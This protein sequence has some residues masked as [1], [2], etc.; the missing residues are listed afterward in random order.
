MSVQC[1]YIPESNNMSGKRSSGRV[2]GLIPF[3]AAAIAL[4]SARCIVYKFSLC[5][6]ICIHTTG[7][8]VSFQHGES[9]NYLITHESG[10]HKLIMS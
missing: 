2:L 9:A 4:Y 1:T 10:N 7:T 8:S 5:I 3:T 6:A